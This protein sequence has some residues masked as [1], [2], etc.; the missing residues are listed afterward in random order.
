MVD[1]SLNAKARN[2]LGKG[3]SRRL[4]RNA[5]LVPAIVYGG[6]K[7]PQNIALEAREL[8]KALENEAFYS[9]VIKLSIDGKKEDVLLKALQ[10][11]P[12]K[13][14][15]MHADFLRVVAGHE[16]TVH[17]PL[18]FINEDSCVGVKKSGG[19]ISHTMTEVEVNCLPK[20]L[21]EFIEVDMAGVD[22]NQIVHLSDLKLP[23]GVSIPFLAQGPDHDLPVANVHAARVAAADDAPAAEGEESAE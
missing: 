13:P 4:R 12:A 1:F 20:D 22:L 7:A 23:K 6:D 9:H 15:I 3:A 14:L 10:R 19:V 11:H 16:V 17:V 5:D 21:P 8:K 18:H 2:D